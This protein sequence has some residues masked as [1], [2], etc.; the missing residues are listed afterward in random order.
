MKRTILWNLYG[1]SSRILFMLLA[2]ALISHVSAGDVRAD[3]ANKDLKDVQQKPA[4]VENRGLL[5]KEGELLRSWGITPHL[6]SITMGLANP[7]M[8]QSTGIY[9]VMP[10][11][12]VGADFDLEKIASIPGSTVHLSYL[13]VPF[14]HGNGTF[15][16]QAGD[17]IVGQAG[18][19]IPWAEHL[20]RLTWEQRFGRAELE[21]GIANAG[22][23][24]AK[25]LCNQP[26]LCQGSM[27]QMSTG[28]NPPPYS[29]WSARLGYQ[30]TPEIKAQF[31]YWRSDP[32]F[33][34]TTGW[35][36]FD[37]PGVYSVFLGNVVYQTRYDQTPYPG[38]YEA[39]LYANDGEQV[40]PATGMSHTGTSGIYLGA[41]Q[42]VWRADGGVPGV[43]HPT[44]VSL[45]GSITNSFDP[46]AGA[47][48]K[49]VVNAGA[50][51]EA[52]FASR[53]FDSY[54]AKFIWTRLTNSKQESLKQANLA[55]GGSG[56]TVPRDQF[57]VGID[58]NWMVAPGLIVS[59]SVMYNWN[60]NTYLNPHFAGRPRDGFS[61]NVTIVALLD[62][63]LGL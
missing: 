4:P 20:Q 33:P 26:A 63:M 57:A 22:D 25:P 55:A 46:D 40:N 48:L 53:P 45:Y 60:V 58:A 50:I 16:M 30:A 15:G 47:G 54:S 62:K 10:I 43:P 42:T 24:F 3:P 17:S 29:N 39:M 14:S 5:A 27:I 6:A 31:G 18:P 51:L 7:S 19:F 49:T 11:L 1:I 2:S 35:Q 41:R 28:I 23:F 44:A 38:T 32:A 37:G 52:P 59:P 12:A 8:G 21:V 61:F 9:E 13:F 34:F 36:S 56:Y